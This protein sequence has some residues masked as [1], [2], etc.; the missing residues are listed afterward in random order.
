MSNLLAKLNPA[1]QAAVKNISGPTL[2]LAG[3]GSGKTGVI[4][5][6]IAYL[7]RECDYAARNVVALTFTNKAAREMKSRVQ[8]ILEKR[9]SRGLWIS[10]F[11]TLGLR[12]L[13][14]DGKAIGLGSQFSIFDQKDCFEVLKD[15]TKLAEPELKLLQ[16]RVSAIKN[17][18][19]PILTPEEKTL[20]DTYQAH[21]LA[22]NAV[23]FDDL[24]GHCLTLFRE[25]PDV[26][27]KWRK[28]V[29]YLLVDEY[30]D[31]NRTQYELVKL[32][33]GE[34]GHFTAVGDDDQSIYSWRGA[35]AENLNALSVDFPALNVIKLE[36]NYRC[37][38]KVLSA[39]NQLIAHNPHVYEKK[40]YSDLES[41]ECISL[42]SGA[43]EDEE[44][45]TLIGKLLTHHNVNGTKLSDYA[46]LYRGNF[47]SRPIEKA[48]R[49]HHLPYVINGSTSFFEHAEIRDLVAYLRLIVNPDDQRA[50]VR[51]INTPKREIGTATIQKLSDYSQKRNLSMFAACREFGLA[52][53]LPAKP[54]QI[55]HDFAEWVEKLHRAAVENGS[56]LEIFNIIVNDIDYEDYVQS[57]YDGKRAE[58]RLELIDELRDWIKRFLEK[59][60]ALSLGEIV[61]RMQLM[62]ML[63][64][65]E[66]E[67][68]YERISLMTL[69]SAKGL[70]FKYVF[71]VGLEEGM[72][73]HRN[74]LADDAMLQEERRLLYVGM[75]RTKIKLW[76][77]FAENRRREGGLHA[78]DA[79]RFI[80]ELPLEEIDDETGKF[81]ELSPEEEQA[82][83][84][85]SFN[86]IMS[87]LE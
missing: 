34:S 50:F 58:K 8:K 11:H 7:I 1:Q 47:Q 41:G 52:Q 49:Q 26:L 78:T 3:A 25:H 37:D 67:N 13:K 36:Q 14:E 79:S 32:L 85:A 43:T 6:K 20:L 65:K 38:V 21:L 18:A 4:T 12:I 48:L 22:L 64:S 68:D 83:I 60:D 71:I 30:Q 77:S 86:D 75:T 69:H 55:L 42:F 35:D 54:M 51:I 16:S 33:A 66:A 56:P 76:L 74:C 19:N 70:E 23:D 81:R 28:R 27:S 39:S 62:D 59:D 15:L 72:L 73:P 29:R 57:Q 24:I 31:T 87:M 61:Q 53:V 82:S 9:E 45:S 5:T 44:A 63:E 46:I 40:L 2:V 84:D 80:Y 17:E 10:T